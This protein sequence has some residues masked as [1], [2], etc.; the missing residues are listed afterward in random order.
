M[1][2]VVVYYGG[3]SNGD[4]SNTIYWFL[5]EEE[6]EIFDEQGEGCECTGSVETFVGSDIYNEALENK[7][8]EL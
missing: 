5:T 7:N 3:K 6:S 1:E 8:I 2:K 4:G